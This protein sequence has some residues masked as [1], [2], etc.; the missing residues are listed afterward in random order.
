MEAK[1]K[2]IR[3]DSRRRQERQPGGGGTGG[4]RC[5]EGPV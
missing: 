1:S 4:P 3:K 2:V 5:G